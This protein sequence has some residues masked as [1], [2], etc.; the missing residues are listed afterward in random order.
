[1]EHRVV[2]GGCRYFRDYEYFCKWVD[3]DLQNLCQQGQI[4]ILSGHCAGT[5]QMAERYARERGYGLE[6]YPADWSMGNRAGPLRNQLMVDKADYVIA[7][8]SGG[9]GTASLI[10]C[11]KQKGIP[12]RLH[13]VS[14]EL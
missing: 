7:F 6:V 10:Q 1:M 11:T 4:V 12:Y 13:D 5:D 3:Y 9:R 14:N 2:I 8:S